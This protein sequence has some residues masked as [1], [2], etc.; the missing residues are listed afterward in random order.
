MEATILWKQ[1][2]EDGKKDHFEGRPIRRVEMG[3]YD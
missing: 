3:D 2:L 1:K